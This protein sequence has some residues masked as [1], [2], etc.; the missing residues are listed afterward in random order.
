MITLL[1]FK[2]F[3]SLDDAVNFPDNTPITLTNL[4]DAIVYGTSDPDDLALLVLLN[5]AEPQVDENGNGNKDTE[6]CQRIPNGSGGARNTSTY[7]QTVPT[8]GAEN[9]IGTIDVPLNITISA[10][11]NGLDADVTISW[12]AVVG[13]TSY[14][15]YRTED[16]NATFPDNW[17]A[18]TGVI[19][20]SWNYTSQ[21]P[22]RRFY[23][24]TA[25]N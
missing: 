5:A 25:N 22:N 8:P 23:I 15:V 12:D 4:V 19:G 1:V 3:L 10:I 21:A 18:Q 16:P 17:T 13:A 6:S 7:A 9:V 2:T 20:T 11:Q 14:T 24:V